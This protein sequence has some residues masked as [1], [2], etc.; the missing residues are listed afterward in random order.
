[1]QK[2]NLS[3]K[4]FIPILLPSLLTFGLSFDRYLFPKSIGVNTYLVIFI[5]ALIT[6]AGLLAIKS[7]ADNYPGWSLNSLGNKFLGPVNKAGVLLWFAIIFAFTALLTDRV[8]DEAGTI[9]LFRTPELVSRFAFLLIAGYMALLGEEALGRLSSVLMVMIPLFLALLFFS[10]RQ[11]NPLN[12]HPVSIYRDLG[13]L[14]KWDLWL[15]TFS[16]V[17]ILSVSTGSK[18]LRDGLKSIILTVIFGALILG[19]ASLAAAGDFGAKGISRYEWPVMSLMNI[20]G[21]APTYFFQNF[22]TTVYFLIL[23]SFSLV[24]AAG[25]LIVAAKG[26]TEFLGFENSRS[27][28]MLFFITIALFIFMAPVTHIT[29]K[30]TANLVLKAGGF[31]TFGYILLVWL[32]SLFHRKE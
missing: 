30:Q 22:I 26:L 14:R 23:L 27:K 9:I 24:T 6:I 7:L 10:F 32:I 29:Y 13:Y 12:I 28:L 3:R 15:L 4:L 8:I 5:G 20:T 25:F 17:W 16:P 2:E 11:V 19:A 31:Y 21:L 18:S 1:M